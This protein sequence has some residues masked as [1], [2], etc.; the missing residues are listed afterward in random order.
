MQALEN[1]GRR[2]WVNTYPFRDA[3]VLIREQLNFAS[4]ARLSD[5]QVSPRIQGNIQRRAIR[6][7]QRNNSSG[8]VD[9]GHRV[10]GKSI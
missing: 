6:P 1:A 5:F 3:L 4:D 2:S 9:A 7:A 8:S 10:Y